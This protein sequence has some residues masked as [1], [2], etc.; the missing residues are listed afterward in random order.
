[1]QDQA[2]PSGS[3]PVQDENS[4]SKFAQDE[5]V[6][7]KAG[8]AKLALDASPEPSHVGARLRNYFL[9]GLVVVGPVTITLYTAWYFFN[10]VDA[11]V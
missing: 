11:W 7:L 6:D 10:M 4:K 1:M 3:R 2:K 8:L 5:T 9:T